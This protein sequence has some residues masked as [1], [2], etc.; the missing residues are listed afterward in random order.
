MAR[1]AS[2]KA[3]RRVVKAVEAQ[4]GVVSDKT[5]SAWILAV[6]RAMNVGAAPENR[7]EEAVLVKGAI[8]PLME[9]V[10][11]TCPLLGNDELASLLWE[12]LDAATADTVAAQ[13]L[14]ATRDDVDGWTTMVVDLRPV[15]TGEEPD[16]RRRPCLASSLLAC[17]A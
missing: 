2:Q 5:A 15:A 14:V 17:L 8:L 4:G 3:V 11:L 13:R 7:R 16:P 9:K 6:R 10:L 12:I 1:T